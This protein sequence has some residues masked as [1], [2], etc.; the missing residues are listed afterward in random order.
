MILPGC[1]YDE[2]DRHRDLERRLRDFL[3]DRLDDKLHLLGIGRAAGH[4]LP[5]VNP[6]VKLHRLRVHAPQKLAPDVPHR[7]HP[8]PREAVVVQ[9]NKPQAHKRHE[10]QEDDDR[11][12]Q[13]ES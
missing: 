7:L 1:P 12:E 13:R 8:R 6:S 2:P 11:E 5:H 10:R 4:Q 3:Q 9:E